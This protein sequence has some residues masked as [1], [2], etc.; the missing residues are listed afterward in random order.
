VGRGGEGAVVLALVDFD[1]SSIGVADVWLLAHASGSAFAFQAFLGELRFAVDQEGQRGVAAGQAV[2]LFTAFAEHFTIAR[3]LTRWLNWRRH[4]GLRSF[5]VGGW[6]ADALGVLQES[7]LAEASDD[8]LPGA[9]RAGMGVGAGRGAGSSA[10]VE[11]FVGAAFGDWWHHH[12]RGGWDWVDL[13][14]LLSHDALSVGAGAEV[15]L[16]AG[17]AGN[18]VTRAKRVGVFAGAVAALALTEFLVLAANLGWQRHDHNDWHWRALL[19][20]DALAIGA[21][22]EVTFLAGAAGDADTRAD[23]VGVL[24]GAVAALALTEFLVVAAHLGWQRHGFGGRNAAGF[25]WHAHAVFVLQVAGL[26]E[27]AD[28]ALH[29]AH[30]AGMWVGAG[31]GA[32]GSARH[33]NFVFLALRDLRRVGEE[34]S[35]LRGFALVGW[36]AQTEFGSQVTWFAEASDDAV[37]GADWARVGVGAGRGARRAAGLEF[38]VVGA[39]RNFKVQRSFWGF[40]LVGWHAETELGSQEAGLAEASDHAVLGA[41]RAGMGIG[42]GRGAGGAAGLEFFVVGALGNF[43]FHGGFLGSGLAF[44]RAH[45]FTLGVLQESFLAETVHDALEGTQ[46]GCFRIGAIRHAGGA[47]CHENGISAAFLFWKSRDGDSEPEGANAEQ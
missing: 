3:A 29:G 30:R 40:A 38:L 44:L 22:A 18:A 23:G 41:D 10:R 13:R 32:G 39:L 16:L 6:H 36:H 1:A 46:F 47:A 11:L 12:E 15:S 24:A 8:A 45:A 34:R 26:A 31:R 25:R 33:E 14:A 19:S 35:G 5:A 7:F 28:H 4:D 17:A 9:D 2:Q 43:E 27:A 20:Q 42:A 37:L 21:V